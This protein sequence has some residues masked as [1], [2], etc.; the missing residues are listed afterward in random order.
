M[1]LPVKIKRLNEKAELP[2][3]AKEG[4]A[5]MDVKAISCEYN[6][7]MDCFIYG[8]GLAFEL[9]ENYDMK[10]YPRSSNRKTDCYLSNSVGILDSGYRGELMLSFK[11]RTSNVIIAFVQAAIKAINRVGKHVGLGSFNLKVPEMVFPYA[12][13]DRIAQI[14]INRYPTVNWIE[15]DKLS[16]SE[17]GAGGHG[18]TGK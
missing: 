18:S 12:I 9:P 1:D 15:V 13:G 7:E 10:I 11:P 16:D 8:T 6:A 14:Q 5:C 17:R 4:D 2:K 3:Y